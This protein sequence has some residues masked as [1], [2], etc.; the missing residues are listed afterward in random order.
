MKSLF[1]ILFITSLTYSQ[2]VYEIPFASKG[3][4]I[5]LTVENKST[6]EIQN[7][8][9]KAIEIPSW[10]KF[11]EEERFIKNL[12][13]KEES[14]A[15][16]KFALEKEAPVKEEAKLKFEIT[17]NKGERWTKEIM[18]KVEAPKKFEL[19]QNYPNPFNPTTTISYTIPASSQSFPSQ[20][21]GLRESS[22]VTLT[23]YDILGREVET[24]VN[25]LQKPGYYKIIWN[26][27]NYASGMYIYQLLM[28]GNTS[29]SKVIRKKM[30]LLR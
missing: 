25:K 21:E 3:N 5:E 19:N 10:V 22:F 29:H 24:L 23:I 28:N 8:K 1:I 20:G 26:A 27:N 17:N 7:V 11:N 15:T 12:K 13:G 30:L 6:I 16:F 14:T 4:E 18:I 9:V 2:T